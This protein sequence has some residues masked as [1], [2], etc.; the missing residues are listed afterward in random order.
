MVVYVSKV[1]HAFVCYNKGGN[2]SMFD[3]YI[4]QQIVF[5]TL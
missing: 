5:L 2:L 4:V 1:P 3:H